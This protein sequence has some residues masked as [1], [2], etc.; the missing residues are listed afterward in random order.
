MTELR[1]R[2]LKL[3]NQHLAKG[4]P[5]G[6]FE[7]LYSAAGEDSSGIPW[8]DLEP[9]PNLV[10]WC[11]REGLTGKGQALKVGCGLGD[12]AEY[13]S[14]LGYEVLAFD[15]APS[16]ITACKRRFPGSSVDYLVADLLAPSPCM[17]GAFDLVV[18]AY[19]LQVL[20][21]ELQAT[22]ARSLAR[23]LAP[24]GRLLVIC[25]AR[26]EDEPCP[27]LHWPLTRSAF[28]TF[29]AEGLVEEHFEDFLDGELPPVRRFRVSYRRPAKAEDQA[30]GCPLPSA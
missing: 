19:T 20:P 26:D 28:S 16:A 15:V 10:V 22:A 17:Q 6:W 3:R 21:P 11:E 8:A 23:A 2:V 4:D 7:A 18:E 27:G 5:L 12:D 30:G 25:R 14:G 13:L 24:G 29:E 1:E 9:N